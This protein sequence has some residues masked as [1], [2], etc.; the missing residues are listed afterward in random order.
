MSSTREAKVFYFKSDVDIK[1]YILNLKNI[2]NP[3]NSIK[4][5]GNHIQ[6]RDIKED[7]G[8]I[9]G[10]ICK[11]REIEK[12]MVGS[13]HDPKESYL[14]SD[15]IE[16]SH[17]IYSPSDLKVIMQ[18][19]PYVSANPNSLLSKLLVKTHI[20]DLPS[21]VGIQAIIRNDAVKQLYKYRGAIF[22]I[23]VKTTKEGANIIAKESGDDVEMGDD[24]LDGASYTERTL[25]YKMTLGSVSETLIEKIS[26]LFR[27]KKVLDASFMIDGNRSPI[28][29]SEFAKYEL[30][31]I[32]VNN[33][34]FDTLDF[35]YRLLQL[36]SSNEEA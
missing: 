16:S 5:R 15:I 23:K 12:P 9:V 35:Q 28:K 6:L 4:Y 3:E 2:K 11:V 26:N 20:N 8:Y 14:E 31:N 30:L 13:A 10:R 19:N 33:G 32:E 22:Q 18:N 24:F 25:S 1:S 34:S 21:G 36:V 7:G 17:F 27:S 29:L